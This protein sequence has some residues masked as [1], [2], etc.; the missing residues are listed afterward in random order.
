MNDKY[1]KEII[2]SCISAVISASSNAVQWHNN[3]GY[4]KN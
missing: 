4:T 3:E 2:R 1:K